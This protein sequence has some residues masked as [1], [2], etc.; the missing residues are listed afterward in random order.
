MLTIGIPRSRGRTQAETPRSAATAPLPVSQGLFVRMAAAVGHSPDGATTAAMLA[1]AR[2]AGAPSPALWHAAPPEEEAVQ[3]AR[4]NADQA[5]RVVDGERAQPS[6]PGLCHEARCQ[7]GPSMGY[8]MQLRRHW[9][10]CHSP[11]IH[12]VQCPAEGCWRWLSRSGDTA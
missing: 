5:K 6:G 12:L 4:L 1:R 10:E 2:G 3:V 8:Y 7:H 11:Y 9:N